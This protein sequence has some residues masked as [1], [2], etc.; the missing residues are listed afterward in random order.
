MTDE[1]TPQQFEDAG[2]DTFGPIT[3][4][5]A[6]DH[7]I[8]R[9]G[10]ASLLADDC[11]FAIVGQGGNGVTVLKDVKNLKPRVVVLDI[12]MPG[13]N[14]LD[15][16]REITRHCDGVG[17]LILSMHG[18]TEF[19][20]RA[21]EYGALGYLL[22]ESAAKQLQEAVIAVARGQV[23]VGPG[24]PLSVLQQANKLGADP[25]EQLSLREKQ[26]LRLVAEGKTNRKIAEELKLSVKTV[27]THRT[28]M[29]RKLNIHNQTAL[30]KFAL[31][32]GIVTI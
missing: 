8:V 11:K 27:D 3:V 20:R 9:Q 18:N 4:Y 2:R 12:T 28:R 6:D 17:V 1:Q 10:L 21:L 32:R 25:Y 26:V 24:I 7:T 19:V 31:R 5:L 16:C 15:T 22:K 14:G 30:V 23:Y 13:L 29:M